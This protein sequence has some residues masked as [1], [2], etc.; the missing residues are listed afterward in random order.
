MHKDFLKFYGPARQAAKFKKW[1]ILI[2]STQNP[3][4]NNFYIKFSLSQQPVPLVPDSLVTFCTI[5]TMGSGI[6]L[7]I[8]CDFLREMKEEDNDDKKQK[9]CI[10]GGNSTITSSKHCYNISC[11]TGIG[12]WVENK[13]RVTQNLNVS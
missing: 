5:S 11:W 8:C 7:S 2:V 1:E 9:T 12:L 10:H 6:A 3:P 13:E 4:L